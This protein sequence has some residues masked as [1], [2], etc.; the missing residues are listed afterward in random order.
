[1]RWGEESGQILPDPAGWG[2]EFGFDSEHD[3]RPLKCS[4]QEIDLWRL[5]ITLVL[6]IGQER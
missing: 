5:K 6:G 1:M 2:V 4:K 3:G